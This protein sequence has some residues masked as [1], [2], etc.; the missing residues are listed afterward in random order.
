M[1]GNINTSMRGNIDE[2]RPILWRVR[3]DRRERRGE[4]GLT[5]I[6]I[7]ITI[8]LLTIGVVGIAGGIASAERIASISQQQAQLEVEMRQLSDWV[9][10]STSAGLT[11]KV[12]ATDAIY[13][14]S[15]NAAITAGVLTPPPGVQLNVTQVYLSTSGS[16]NGVGT[17]PLSGGTCS[18]TCPGASCVG[19]WGVQEIALKITDPTGSMGTRVVTRTVWKGNT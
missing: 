4:R 2:V 16:R 7:I 5:L 1:R 6:E 17:G 14:A 19:D 12:C 11:Y 13:Q 3:V 8:A 10:D 9:R 15:V 18:G